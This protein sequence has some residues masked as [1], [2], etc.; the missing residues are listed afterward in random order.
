MTY[1]YF[2]MQEKVQKLVQVF[3][4]SKIKN[5]NIKKNAKPTN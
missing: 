2:Q 1:T 3:K 5:R 4:K